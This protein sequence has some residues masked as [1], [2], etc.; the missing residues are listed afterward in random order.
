MTDVHRI[1]Y[2]SDDNETLKLSETLLAAVVDPDAD[3]AESA[4]DAGDGWRIEVRIVDGG[5]VE[6]VKVRDDDPDPDPGAEELP[7]AEANAA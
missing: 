3:L 5:G 4:L 6:I 7:E 1:L 2:L